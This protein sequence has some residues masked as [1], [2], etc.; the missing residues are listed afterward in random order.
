MARKSR[1][2]VEV[3]QEFHSLTVEG[4]CGSYLK[5]KCA[6]GTSKYIAKCSVV[7]GRTKSCGCMRIARMK[8]LSVG[9]PQNV[10]H[11]MSKSNTYKHWSAMRTRC[12]PATKNKG[13]RAY[14]VDKGVKV[15]QRWDGFENFLA[16][17]GEAPPGK[18]LDRFPDREGNYE[19]GNCRW[20][21]AQEQNRNLSSNRWVGINGRRRVVS[22]WV[23]LTGLSRHMI[24]KLGEADDWRMPG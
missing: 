6:C 16:D 14:Y 12:N 7:S 18:S 2:T 23:D 4:L 17:M 8:K 10:K 5:C 3:G 11:M 21:T 13:Y 19:P 9:Q 1:F 22:E 24:L 20:A 15:S